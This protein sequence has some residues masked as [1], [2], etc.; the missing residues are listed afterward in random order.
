MKTAL[1]LT[2][3]MRTLVPKVTMTNQIS[4]PQ[5]NVHVNCQV[6]AMIMTT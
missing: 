2:L 5:A 6:I 4:P 3:E 1:I